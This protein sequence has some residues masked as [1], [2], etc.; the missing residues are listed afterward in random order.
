MNSATNG[1]CEYWLQSVRRCSP[2]MDRAL[3]N[4]ADIA[5]IDYIDSVFRYSEHSFQPRSDL[6]DVLYDYVEPLL[7][8][9]L[10]E[11]VSEDLIRHPVVLTANHHGVDYFAQSVQGSLLFS[12]GKKQQAGVRTAP[13]FACGNIPLDNLTY[14]RG[15]LI[16][17]SDEAH[18]GPKKLPVFSNKV[19]RQP[20]S[21][22]SGVDQTKVNDVIK[23]MAKTAQSEPGSGDSLTALMH[24]LTEDYGSEAVCRHARYSDQSVIINHRIWQRLFTD[25]SLIPNL[26]TLELEEIARRLLLKDLANSNSLIYQLL[27]RAEMRERLISSLDGVTG[28]WDVSQMSAR[29]AYTNNGVALKTEGTGTFAFWGIDEA[30]RRV[31]LFPEQQSQ[32]AVLMGVSD[33]AQSQSLA[34][35]PDELINALKDRRLLPSLFSCFT[36]IALAR[37]VSC[38]GGYYQAEYLPAIQKGVVD[39]LQTMAEQ[40]GMKH[41]IDA[42]YTEGYLSGMQMVMM[43]KSQTVYPVGPLEIIAAG[44]LSESDLTKMSNISVENA[45]LASLLE[46]ISDV[47]PKNDLTAEQVK[48]L[49][50][51]QYSRL[52]GSVLLKH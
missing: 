49:L 2:V 35:E 9:P 28:C 22:V 31:P 1:L 37:G 17:Q 3:R 21:L 5:V 19:R 16:Y 33:S 38:L 27:F 39:V 29:R 7:G 34:L 10:A 52:G 41:V 44:G 46:T 50:R 40:A 51:E 43:E 36:V 4:H 24:I 12:M 18:R 20:V 14:P 47:V 26:I 32:G 6:G 11:Q 30:N 45:H 13:V 15:A 48:V 8:Q 23:R 25:Q 42:S